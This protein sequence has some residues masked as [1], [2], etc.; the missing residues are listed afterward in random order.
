MLSLPDERRADV[1]QGIEWLVHGV[2]DEKDE[3]DEHAEDEDDLSLLAGLL[4]ESDL[5]DEES[6]EDAEFIWTG[7][8]IEVTNVS[9]YGTVDRDAAV[10]DYESDADH[11]SIRARVQESN[12]VDE[13][14]AT[15]AGLSVE[16][17][18]TTAPT[19]DLLD[20]R[21]VTRL[22][23]GDTTVT[24]YYRRPTTRPGDDIAVGVSID[25]SGSMS[26]YEENAKA[27]LGTFLF[28]VQELGGDVVANAWQ[29]QE[30][31]E[32][33]LLT[34]P[35]EPFRWR[36]L[37]AVEPGG[38]DPIALG[39]GDCGDLLRATQAEERL[40][41]VITDGKP[42]VQ[43]L[44]HRSFDDPIDEAAEVARSLRM[45]GIT[46]I[47]VGFGRVRGANL[48]E[49]FGDPFAVH[50]ELADLA[51]ELARTL[52]EHVVDDHLQVMV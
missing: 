38:G 46:V 37:D 2:P 1:E 14:K 17:H 21:N 47:G 26:R 39:M 18:E 40:L 11:R 45:L 15:L 27:A 49:M 4:A 7:D 35:H 43:S 51:D 5:T 16:E 30:E 23:A 8:S 25:M 32:I 42:T 20:M 6:D 28:S 3:A 9:R 12:L 48:V 52:V 31:I 41:F 10:A 22:L 24:D 33:R 44:S 19:G 50:V 29:Y 34:A 13:M 36:H